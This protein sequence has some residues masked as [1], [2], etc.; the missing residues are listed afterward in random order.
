MS[1]LKA[2]V[3]HDG[4]EGYDIAYAE[5]EGKAQAQ[6][7]S[8]LG[9]DCTEVTCRR[10]PEFDQYANPEQTWPSDEVLLQN[11]WYLECSCGAGLTPA[12]HDANEVRFTHGNDAICKACFER[13]AGVTV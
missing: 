1:N 11:G 2:Y 7:A 12:M 5:T 9:C 13:Q 8:F 10:A 6:G 4:D 3:I